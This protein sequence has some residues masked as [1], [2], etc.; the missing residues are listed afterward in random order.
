MPKNQKTKLKSGSVLEHIKNEVG[1]KVFKDL[2]MKTIK[3]GCLTEYFKRLM[4]KNNWR[5]KTE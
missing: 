4:R 2:L 5:K 1:D 3:K